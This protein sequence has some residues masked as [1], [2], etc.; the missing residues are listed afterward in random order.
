M[1]TDEALVDERVV[2]AVIGHLNSHPKS[3]KEQM[4][5]TSSLP[6]LLH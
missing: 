6:S 3:M 2:K 5:Q 1:K 4:E